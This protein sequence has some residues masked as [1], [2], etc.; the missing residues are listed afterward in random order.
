MSVERTLL[1]EAAKR[2]L[3]LDGAMG[4]MIQ[5]YKLDVSSWIKNQKNQ[6]RAALETTDSA[7]CASL[8]S[9]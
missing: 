4:T 1:A 3:I 5:D 9:R 6:T 7:A 2:I 8:T